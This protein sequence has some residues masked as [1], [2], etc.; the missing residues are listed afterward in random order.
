[1][2]VDIRIIRAGQMYRYYLRETVVGDHRRPARTPLRAAQEQA[3]VPV[4]RWMGRGLA[5][6]GLPPGEEVTEAQLRNLRHHRTSHPAGIRAA[7]R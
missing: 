5:A 4:G 2:T 6:L 3:G 7:D 1:M